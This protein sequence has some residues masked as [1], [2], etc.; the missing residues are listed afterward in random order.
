MRAREPWTPLTRLIGMR[1]TARTPTLKLSRWPIVA[2]PSD[3]ALPSGRASIQEKRHK[4][5]REFAEAR[6][7]KELLRRACAVHDRVDLQSLG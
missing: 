3:R 6:L 2:M 1:L 7:T 5:L 4:C